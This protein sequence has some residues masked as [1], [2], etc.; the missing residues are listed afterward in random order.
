[1][2]LIPRLTVRG[3]TRRT[4]AE[5]GTCQ[6]PPTALQRGLAVLH[7]AVPDAERTWRTTARIGSWLTPLFPASEPRLLIPARARI[8][9]S[10]CAVSLR[11]RARCRGRVETSP[12]RCRRGGHRTSHADPVRR[13]GKGMRADPIVI[14][15]AEQIP[16][17]SAFSD[18]EERT[19]TRHQPR[20]ELG[21]DAVTANDRSTKGYSLVIP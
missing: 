5:A 3:F 1:M 9:D 13:S 20:L 11:A 16:V 6:L 12:R 19:M 8:A 21:G 17:A 4:D 7:N 15:D 2:P 10:W 18:N 14:E